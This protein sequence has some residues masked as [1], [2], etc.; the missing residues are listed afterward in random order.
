MK[1]QANNDPAWVSRMAN[2]EDNSEISVGGL[3]HEVGLFD[4]PA[5]PASAK[6]ALAKLIE[7]RRRERRLT[8]EQLAARAEVETAELVDIELGRV[9]AP[10][11][12]T[13]AKLADVLE[14]PAQKLMQ[15]S[16]SVIPKNARFTEAVV[17]FA[18]KSVPVH[19]LSR[20]EREA[21]DE[22]VKFLAEP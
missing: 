21:L 1:T 4:G 10:Q 2:L 6:S 16:G 11:L 3:A 15:L 9:D 19:H 13:V 14:L 17:R 5:A 8:V 18:A 20:E 12:R 22:F 7:L